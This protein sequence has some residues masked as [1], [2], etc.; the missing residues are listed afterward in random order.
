MRC[1]R[2]KHAFFLA[3]PSASQTDRV[4]SI[5]EDAASALDSPSAAQDLP[6]TTLDGLVETPDQAPEAEP[7]EEDWQFS[8]EIRVEGDDGPD[9]ESTG[10]FST[11]ADSESEFGVSEDFGAGF[12][13]S[14]LLAEVSDSD[15]EDALEAGSNLAVEHQ[16]AP[17]A[18]SPLEA[19]SDSET[20]LPQ[21]DPSSFGSVDDYS[22]LMED[23]EPFASFDLASEIA[24]ELAVEEAADLGAV[25]D[26]ESGPTDDLGDPESWDLVGSDDLT[27]ERSSNSGLAQ[28]AYSPSTADSEET[29]EFFSDEGY[30]E[31]DYDHEA[32][33]SRSS[34][35]IAARVGRIVGWTTSVALAGGVLFLALQTEWARWAQAPQVV[36]HGP[37]YAETTS[38]GWVE[39]SRSGPILRFEGQIRNTGIKAIWP[40]VIQLALLDGAGERL[41]AMPIQAGVP[42][43]KTILREAAPETIAARAIAASRRLVGTPLAP[44]E[45]RTFEA[46]LFS[47]QLPDQAQRVLLEVGESRVGAAVSGQLDAESDS[48]P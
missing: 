21:R 9:D 34:T 35:G 37:L 39:T 15:A 25:L 14:A 42:I 32:G 18:A 36:S 10:E 22:E 30:G 3:S 28:S 2:C 19:A 48:S 7:E 38:S 13:E 33:S 43:S 26:D 24:S 45:A 41:A 20:D 46:L 8:E 47:D 44:G 1:S 31:M 27:A 12:D 16:A 6:G 17:S 29:D 40:G 23:E 5:A 4:H 11:Q